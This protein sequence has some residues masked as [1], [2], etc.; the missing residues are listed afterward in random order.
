[1]LLLIAISFGAIA[2]VYKTNTGAMDPNSKDKI[3]VVIPQNSTARTVGEILKDKGLIKNVDFF[4]LYLKLFP[5]K[6][7]IKAST[8]YLSKDM[9]LDDIL[10]TITEG[11]SINN[12][13][14]KITFKEGINI[15]KFASL[16]ESKTS[17]T[18]Q[19]VYDLLKDY[20]YLNE[21]IENY[22]FIDKSIK[23]DNIYYSLEGYLFPDTYYF[24]NKDVSVK[25]IIKKMLDREEEILEEYKDDIA[26]SK[27]SVREILIMASII[28][29][30][31]KTKDF[32]KIASVFYNRLSISM[33]LESCAT[34]YYGAKKEFSDVGI[35]TSEMIANDNPYNTYMYD[36]LPVGPIS[37]PSKEAI[38]AAVHP[39]DTEYVYFLSDNEGVTYFFNTYSE[40]QA[41]QA[42]LI[43]AGKWER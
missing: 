31:G 38:E 8:Y 15:R 42:E 9:T 12:E 17:N 7:D 33:K 32:D 34:L 23:E 13:Q 27:Y 21:L 4:A 39:A 19:D 24:V 20:E 14:I 28:E 37:L 43:K 10:K 40:H 26:A 18:E 16:V 29:K 6:K 36:G 11:N 5:L 30:E 3:E 41:K 22:W 35:A 1:M 2:F 25:D